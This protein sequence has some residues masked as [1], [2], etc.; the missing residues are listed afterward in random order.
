MERI[1]YSGMPNVDVTDGQID[2]IVGFVFGLAGAI[3]LLFI[4]IG[5]VR[6]MLS[7]GDP[8]AT[9]QS[10]NAIL[11]AIVGLLITIFA[12]SITRFVLGRV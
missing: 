6:Y 7:Q 10:K 9:G 11:Y 12:Y 3:A 4:V 2:I 8:Q 1:K 5:G